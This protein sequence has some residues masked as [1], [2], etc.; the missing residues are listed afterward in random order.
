M[1]LLYTPFLLKFVDDTIRIGNLR[2]I[3]RNIDTQFVIF[4]NGAMFMLQ[5]CTIYFLHAVTSW[6]PGWYFSG[7][8]F[9]KSFPW[10]VAANSYC[11][12][13]AV[14]SATKCKFCC[15]HISQ[16]WLQL[17]I[18]FKM[19]GTNANTHLVLNPISNY[20]SIPRIP[21]Y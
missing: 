2:T 19:T 20:P 13:S 7:A 5:Q 10:H 21:P 16:I 9:T 6:A 18:S 11:M 4:P 15:I 3:R 17:H 8:Y 1:H 14:L 12:M